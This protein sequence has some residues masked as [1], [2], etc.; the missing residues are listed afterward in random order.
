M[1]EILVTEAT[2]WNMGQNPIL[3]F[4]LHA[5]LFLLLFQKLCFLLHIFFSSTMQT[6]CLLR[7]KFC[8]L[9][10]YQHN[11]EPQHSLKSYPGN[12]QCKVLPV[13]FNIDFFFFIT[14]Q[15]NKQQKVI[16]LKKE[17]S[18]LLNVDHVWEK[19]TNWLPEQ[20]RRQL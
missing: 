3:Q 15:Q 5:F 19:D 8:K 18:V 6:C 4:A 16:F 10:E 14:A 20:Q 1:R 13:V 12:R 17:I 7:C 9:N 11:W 2:L